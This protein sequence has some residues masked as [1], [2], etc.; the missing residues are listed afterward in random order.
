MPYDHQSI[1]K[2]W[3]DQWEKTGAFTASDD[4]AKEKFYCLIEFPYPSGAGLHLGHPRSY[5]ALDIVA[6]RKRMEGKNVLYPIG[7]DAFGLPTENYAIKTGRTPQEIT[8]ENTDTFRRQLKALGLSF[9]WSREINT[10]DPNYYRWTQWMFLEFFRA[11]LAYKARTEINWC[12]KDKIGLANEEAAGGVCDRC[13]GPV[14]KRE[15]EQWM[16]AI[17]KYAGRL[18][19][20]LDTVDYLPNIKTQQ[21]NWIGKSEGMVFRCKVKDT[22]FEFDVFDSVPQTFTA[23]TFSVI[24]ADHPKLEDLVKGTPDEDSVLRKAA[25]IVKKKTAAGREDE[26]DVDG[27]FTGRYLEDPYGTG[28]LPLWVASYAI[29]DYGSGVV[30]GS[31]HDERDFV[32]AKKFG[33]PLRPV[34][35]PKDEQEAQRVRNL[36]YCYHHAEDGVLVTPKE[37]A[38]RKWGEVRK[39]IL[40]YLEGK[41]IGHRDV[42][43]KLRDWVFSRQ[44]YWG[45]PIPLVHCKSG[46]AKEQGGWMAVPDDQL[47]VLLPEVE[48]YQPTD[49]GESPLA[50]IPEFVNAMCPSCGGPAKRETDTMPNWAGSSWYF[51][52]YVDPHNDEA[53][54]SKEKLA[55]WMPV[56]LYNGGMEHTVLHLLYSRFWHKFLFDRGHVPTSE[57]YARRHSHGLILAADGSKMSK[58]KGNVV[59]PDDLVREYGADALRLY[60]MFMGPFEEAIPWNPHGI[61]GVRRFL[62]KVWNL[63]ERLVDASDAHMVRSAHQCVKQVSKDIEAFK[64]NTAVATLMKFTNELQEQ[65]KAPRDAYELLLKLLGVFAP[66]IAEELWEKLGHQ[67]SMF[68]EAWPSY[69]PELARDEL[70]EVAIQVNGKL[71]GTMMIAPDLSEAEAGKRAQAIENVQKHLEGKEIVKTIYVPGRLM[72]FVVKK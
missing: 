26:K 9:D 10:T 49:T 41:G 71:R 29:A 47:P 37:F 38:G 4:P 65:E 67:T 60:E 24:A 12:P 15:K 8:K 58:S 7:W 22:D 1:E 30:N 2:K 31:A 20:D 16:I 21:Q 72:N 64:F 68:V 39:D 28:D 69:D 5:T 34:M 46:C 45:E 51:L 40:L 55:Y 14:E 18:L 57:P 13:G 62:E 36:E 23:Q 6:R 54:A 70:S 32:F 25:D 44:R 63:S 53:F 61:V 48:R 59:N 33:I 56:D 11:G 43:Y 17:T 66:H 52:R 27:I 50:N 42:Q 35:F 19:T 3:Q